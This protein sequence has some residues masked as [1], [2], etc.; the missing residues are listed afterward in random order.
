MEL[1]ILS[2][3]PNFILHFFFVWSLQ[4]KQ[5]IGR[6]RSFFY[7]NHF[8]IGSNMRIVIL[9]NLFAPSFNKAFLF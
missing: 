2:L 5:L 3:L 8:L 6:E 1:S 4:S 9:C 7:F